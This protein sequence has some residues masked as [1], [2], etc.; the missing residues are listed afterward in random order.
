MWFN[1]DRP[2][3]TLYIQFKVEQVECTGREYSLHC[4]LDQINQ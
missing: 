2:V 4:T 1:T 3:S